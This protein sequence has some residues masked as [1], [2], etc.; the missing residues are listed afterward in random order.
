MNLFEHTITSLDA[1]SKIFQNTEAFEPLVRHILDLHGLPQTAV[2]NTTPG[3]HAV[4]RT[5]GYIVK[6]Y[7]PDTFGWPCESDFL[8]EIAAMRHANRLGIAVPELIAHG[9]I[10]DRYEFR[11]LIQ[12]F[13][14]GTEFGKAELTSEEKYAVGQQL[15]EICD[16][17]NV[18]CERFN[19]YDFP[20]DAIADEDEWEDFTAEFRR[21]R[22]EYLRGYAHGTP[23]Y[24]HGDI[25][26]DNAILDGQGRAWI[27]D[28][29]DSVTAPAEYEYA[30][31]F[32]GL[33]RMEKAYLDGFFGKDQWTAADV[34]EKLTYGFCLH[35]FGGHII[36]DLF[37]DCGVF[38]SVA[39]LREA[40]IRLT[41]NGGMH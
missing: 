16:K 11:Y 13:V 28:F 7:A 20:E 40:I 1:W 8:T 34:A 19:D 31:L 2:E 30:S 22:E 36:R 39:D 4:F 26:I 25:H 32:P 21:S 15:R 23:V 3:S 29:A 10:Y 12:T 5:G 38:R 14:H 41:E 6:V 18:P 33:F 35:R 37:G 24:V 9:R 27:L 17:M